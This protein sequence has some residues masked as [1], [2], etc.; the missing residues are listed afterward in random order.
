MYRNRED[1]IRQRAHAIW[2]REGRHEEH[3]R[4]AWAEIEREDGS[5]LKGAY[6]TDVPPSGAFG[7]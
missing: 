4:Q 6:P 3:W 7:G 1:R 2:E 5:D